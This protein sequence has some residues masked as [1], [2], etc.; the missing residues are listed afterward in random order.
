[1][2]NSPGSG[3]EWVIAC[4]APGDVAPHP[5]FQS[6][7]VT[8]VSL[9]ALCVQSEHRDYDHYRTIY[10][11]TFADA[12][13]DGRFFL[14]SVVSAFES[15]TAADGMVNLESIGSRPDLSFG[16][17]AAAVL[18]AATIASELDNL[19]RALVQL[20]SFSREIEGLGAENGSLCLVEA[21]VAQ[22]IAL[23]AFEAGNSEDALNNALIAQRLSTAVNSS[24]DQFP[25]S[26]GIEWGA[27][28]SQRRVLNLIAS[29]SLELL[30]EVGDVP[31]KR[32]A[33]RATPP[34]IGLQQVAQI[35]H[36]L[37]SFA[38]LE[39]RTHYPG[40][41][42]HQIVPG[43]SYSDVILRPI[44]SALRA[45]ELSASW[46][47]V[48]RGRVSVARMLALMARVADEPSELLLNA[49]RLLRQAD[50][51]DDLNRLVSELRMRGPLSALRDAAVR[52][53]ESDELL[54]RPGPCSLLIIDAAGDLLNTEYKRRGV[55]VALRFSERGNSAQRTR[56]RTVGWKL[57]EQGLKVV[58]SCLPG[59]G[60]D[61]IAAERCI[62][63]AGS[64]DVY[65]SQFAL[66]ALVRLAELITWPMVRPEVKESWI[67]YV[68]SIAEV[69]DVSNQSV[70]KLS[71]ILEIDVKQGQ[72]SRLT[73]LQRAAALI[74][75][76]YEAGPSPDLLEEIASDC[77][78]AMRRVRD[79]ARRGSMRLGGYSATA[80]SAHLVIKYGLDQLWPEIVMTLTHPNVSSREKI[81]TLEVFASSGSLIPER[82]RSELSEQNGRTR[83]RASELFFGE[84]LELIDVAWRKFDLSQRLVDPR[85]VQL[86]LAR[87]A[88]ASDDQVRVATVGALRAVSRIA[89]T[90][91]WP[92][93]LLIQLTDD[94]DS[95][96]QHAAARCL[97]DIS[98]T[99]AAEQMPIVRE[100]VRELFKRDGVGAVLGCLYGVADPQPHAGKRAGW[101]RAIVREIS[102]THLSAVVRR[103]ATRVLEADDR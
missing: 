56:S 58:R 82:Y 13:P 22:Q 86:T 97:A 103:A 63:L 7:S 8:A 15:E 81:D 41:L 74:N 51:R 47:G 29:N 93:I 80:L 23:R 28:E 14:D 34:L 44:R 99:P 83:D 59:S 36:G 40:E 37:S 79:D 30:A 10:D 89:P 21:V 45:A 32:A 95:W 26:A 102:E 24:F 42:K 48:A 67:R 12:D 1:M 18:L 52:I 91:Q 85:D 61:D 73:G 88:T 25:V 96:V 53:L 90:D 77:A 98:M 62:E 72:L 75:G 101:A 92:V 2:I 64:A 87:H 55:H 100:K 50:A 65:E 16:Q 78:L 17:R 35:A 76:W 39:Y 49:L 54:S 60:L 5:N 43:L 20:R 70:L 46:D 57:V 71:S 94:T 33:I 11:R 84:S 27:D 19:D 6:E 31:F 3:I 38:E 4:L 68:E 69:R 66:S 9:V